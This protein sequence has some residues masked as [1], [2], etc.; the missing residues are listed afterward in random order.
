M[1]RP[2]SNVAQEIF[3]DLE[4]II[5]TQ[6]G[7]EE[8]TETEEEVI[9]QKDEEPEVVEQTAEPEAEDIPADKPDQEPQP[10]VEGTATPLMSLVTELFPDDSI[11]D[12]LSAIERV[13]GYIHQSRE[14][15]T[16]NREANAKLLEIF[17]QS[18]ELVA[19]I[20]LMNEGATFTEALPY[21]IDTD[22]IIPVEGDPDFDA[23]N[24]NKEEGRKKRKEK[25]EALRQVQQNMD[26]SF[27]S[28]DRFAKENGMS[29]TQ[30]AAFLNQVDELINN[31]SLGKITP[32]ILNKLNKGIMHD[33]IMQEETE[34]A[35]IRGRNTAITEKITK[36][37]EKK[38]G[39]GLPAIKSAS[40]E[41]PAPKVADPTD[42]V[43]RNIEDFVRSKN[44]F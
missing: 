4:D 18:P 22:A 7:D 36:E 33:T 26:I 20:R 15:E 34:K 30:T 31:I 19:I 6:P 40:P 16:K 8:L 14:Y 29:E 44:R 10:E 9:E 37:E 2:E 39:D 25:D 1:P 13:K 11:G 17:N 3:G 21:S 5:T 12:D 43:S 28:V 35:E 23:F 32:E 38:K 41:T 24:R 27:Q 42:I